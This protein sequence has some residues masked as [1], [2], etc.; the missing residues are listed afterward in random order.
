MKGQSEWILIMEM[1]ST[2]IFNSMAAEKN[3]TSLPKFHLP[4]RMTHL[5]EDFSPKKIIRLYMS[6]N[7]QVIHNFPC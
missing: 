7:S 2:S 4:K 1:L 3:P 6:S 5:V